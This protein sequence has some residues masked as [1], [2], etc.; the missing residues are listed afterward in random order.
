[1]RHTCLCRYHTAGLTADGGVYTFGLN[2]YGQL[3]RRGVMGAAGSNKCICDSGGDC[4]CGQ[5]GGPVVVREGEAC[6]GGASCRSGIPTR[7]ALP[8]PAVA[9]A[10]GRYTTV[11]VMGSGELYAWGLNLCA[12]DG[13]DL[14]PADLVRD[15]TRAATPRRVRGFGGPGEPKAVKADVGY[16][17]MAILTEAGDV[18]TCHTGYDGYAGGLQHREKPNAQGELG[19]PTLAD[20]HAYRPGLVAGALEG[21]R[22]VDIATGASPLRW[23]RSLHR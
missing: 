2:D 16:I 18:W 6:H 12:S 7:V 1:V 15:S 9:L 4:S 22:V 13:E 10:A 11:A 5:Q 8:G 19:R 21:Q 20:A 23:V 14:L 17:H 3:G